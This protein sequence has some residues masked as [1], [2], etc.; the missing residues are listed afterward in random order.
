MR[1]A[2]SVS[3]PDRLDFLDS[4]RVSLYALDLRKKELVAP[5]Q[6]ELPGAVARKGWTFPCTQNLSLARARCL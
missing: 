6:L 1:E 3:A 5:A 2:G 4:A